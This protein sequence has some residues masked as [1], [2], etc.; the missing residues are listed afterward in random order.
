M[1][2]SVSVPLAATPD[3]VLTSSPIAT[4]LHPPPAPVE[5]VA[6]AVKAE[7]ADEPR[8][9]VSPVEVGTQTIDFEAE[10]KGSV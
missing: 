3:H 9:V 6:V 7:V 10:I 8:I 2:P 5:E 1:V 4:H